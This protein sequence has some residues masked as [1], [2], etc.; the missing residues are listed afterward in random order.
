MCFVFCFVL[1][2]IWYVCSFARS[3]VPFF[4]HAFALRRMV[5]AFIWFS[6]GKIRKQTQIYYSAPVVRHCTMLNR[7]KLYQQLVLYLL[8]SGV[9]FFFYFFDVHILFI[10]FFAWFSSVSDAFFSTLSIY[11]ICW[12]RLNA[13]VIINRANGESQAITMAVD[14]SHLSTNNNNKHLYAHAHRKP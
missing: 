5:L 1:L 2:M 7:I 13:I 8:C 14:F 4:L 12:W 10:R 6:S 11:V 3:L 9:F